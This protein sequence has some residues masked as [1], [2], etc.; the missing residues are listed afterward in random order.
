MNPSTLLAVLGLFS[1]CFLLLEVFGDGNSKISLLICFR[2]LLIG[3]AIVALHVVV[4]DVNLRIFINIEIHL[5]LAT[6]L[7]TQQVC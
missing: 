4:S 3:H 6:C 7:P 2:Q 5:P 1:V